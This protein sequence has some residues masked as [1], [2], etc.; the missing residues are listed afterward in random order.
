MGLVLLTGGSARSDVESLL[1]LRPASVLFCAFGLATLRREHIVEHRWLL[2][3]A[4]AIM[5]FVAVQIVPLPPMLWQALPGRGIIVDIDKAVGLPSAWRPISMAPQATWNALFALFVPLG[6]LLVGLRL[7]SNERR[8]LLLVLLVFGLLSGLIGLLQVTGARGGPLYFYRIT[9][10]D[11]AVGLFANRNHQALMLASMFPMLAV[12]AWNGVEKPEQ[13]RIRLIFSIC[14]GLILVPLLLVTG[15]RAGFALMLIG[16]ICAP[17]LYRRPIF[18]HAPRRRHPR[19]PLIPALAVGVAVIAIGLLTILFSRA[20][21][22]SRIMA[23]GQE[24]DLRFKVW[25]PVTDMAWRY[26]PVG[27]GTGTFPDIFQLNEPDSLLKPTYLNHAHN[28]LL[29][30]VMT[31][32]ALAIVLLLAALALGAVATVQ[33]WRAGPRSQR[34]IPLA[35]AG[36]FILAMG[37]LASLADY[38]LRVPMIECVMVIAALW[39]TKPGASD[40]ANSDGSFEESRLGAP[41][42]ARDYNDIPR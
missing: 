14:A 40:S 30:I 8:A 23:P 13:V 25:G 36:S 34:S 26:F 19:S 6:V 20:Q 32:G 41:H 3:F 5:A 42:G 17:I 12:Y 10:P 21:T 7:R 27:S 24:E 16:L 33:A 31:G 18:D 38:P 22:V 15:S 11:A 29:E 37:A 28:D 4:A 2:G 1:V 9:N 35:R 39:L